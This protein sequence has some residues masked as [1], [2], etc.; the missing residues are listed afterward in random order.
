MY[1]YDKIPEEMK[2]ERRWVLWQ[3]EERDGRVTKIPFDPNTGAMAK[4]NDES[5]WGTFEQCLQ[6]QPAYDGLGFMLGMG[7]FGV[8]LDHVLKNDEGRA[9]A[10]DFSEALNT[11]CEVSQSGDGI[12]FIC[13]GKLPSGRR[14][15]GNIEMYDSARFF[16]LT[17]NRVKGCEELRECTESIKALYHKYLDDEAG[18]YVYH[19]ESAPM[20]D[21]EVISKALSCGDQRFYSLFYGKW[22]EEGYPSQSEADM[23]FA[24]KLAFWTKKDAE[25][26]D[27]IFR[28]SGLM[29]E[30]WN[31]QRGDTT[32]GAQTI[33]SAISRCGDVYGSVGADDSLSFPSS[34]VATKKREYTLDDTGNA[35]RFADR[36][37]SSV[38]YNFDNKTWLVWDGKQWATDTKEVVRGYV[39]ALIQE[40]RGEAMGQADQKTADTLWKNVKHLSSSNG[41]TAMLKEAQHL[42][43]IA[44]S[45]AD[46]SKNPYLLNT[47]NGI[48]DLRTGTNLP[49]RRE[50]MMNKI[51]SCP[52]DM[53]HEPE[54]WL[55]TLD[56]IFKGDK[57][58]I[59]FVQKALGYTI[60]GDTKETC[61]FQCHGK[62]SN[63]KSLFFGAV[64]DILNSYALNVQVESILSRGKSGNAGNASSDIARMAGARFV[65]TNEPDD[66]A[67]F[68]EGLVKQLTG[69]DPVTARFL[70]GKEFEFRPEF[71]LWI[72]CNYKIEVRGTDKG[73]WRRMRLIPFE[74]CFEGSGDD[75]T[76]NKRLEEEY[77]AILGWLVKG[78]LKW[79]KEGLEP[80]E[81]VKRATMEYKTEMDIVENFLK[82]KTELD[83]QSYEKA[84]KLYE[85]YVAWCRRGNEAFLSS[86]KF[87]TEMT[88]RFQKKVIGGS[89]YYCGVKLKTDEAPYI[90]V[91][92]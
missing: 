38:R 23:A 67:R 46:F 34:P 74:A 77:P 9:M 73:I 80:P 54:L 3:R 59:D 5:T 16:A 25:Q 82:E 29:R 86:V 18:K 21:E 32:Y 60:T 26:M 1:N 85:V 36:F 79:Q 88:T 8:D 40:M 48:V 78:C 62:G 71:K 31:K 11:Y 76:L 66:G 28:K 47:Q 83:P 58:L 91:K 92:E 52:C 72:A 10:R 37:G 2:K 35:M 7:F 68:A 42:D 51:T 81:S 64:Y 24:M 19:D 57:E 55:K 53:E 65:R 87:G 27:R 12:H 6:K 63:G 44:S 50:E 61:F 15:K 22:E 90:Y 33:A 69:S 84:S 14:R 30:K 89:R 17:G 20:T 45:N 43:G 56:G 75:K 41:K 39:D 49:H 4:S 70:Y 13:R